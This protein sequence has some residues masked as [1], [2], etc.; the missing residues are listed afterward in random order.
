MLIFF[1]DVSKHPKQIT[2]ATHTYQ[3]L[4]TSSLDECQNIPNNLKKKPEMQ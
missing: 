2:T 3:L 1:G 4:W